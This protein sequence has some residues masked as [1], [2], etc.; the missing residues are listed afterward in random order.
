M[1]TRI[2]LAGPT[3]EPYDQ[4]VPSHPRAVRR[5]SFVA[6]CAALATALTVTP[7][8]PQVRAD[9]GLTIE[10]VNQN[11]AVPDSQVWVTAE[12]TLAGQ[13][14]S[15][16]AA[17]ESLSRRSAFTAA[18]VN[19]GRVSISFDQPVPGP[20]A[21]A[22]SPDTSAIRFDVV[23]LTY[24]GVANLT[25]VDMFGIPLDLEVYDSAGNL[26]GARR[27]ICYTDVIRSQL[28]QRMTAAGGTYSRAERRTGS[29]DFLR[30][31]SPNI[32]SGQNP[33]G[34][35][36]L[37]DYVTSLKGQQLTVRGTFTGSSAQPYDFRGSFSGPGLGTLRLQ[38][39]LGDGLQDVVIDGDTL[40]GNT[41]PDNA[42]YSNNGPYQLGN[43]PADHFVGENDVY[44]AVYRDVVAGFAWG[45]WGS[46]GL[47]N[48]TA[49]FDVSRSPGP[50]EGAQPSHP[51]YNVWAAA[52][53]GYT[54]AYGFPFS[55]TFNDAPGR[56]PLLGL[57]A[58]GTLRII[59][60][61]DQSPS[62]CTSNT[63]DRPDPPSKVTGLKVAVIHFGHK[64]RAKWRAVSMATAYQV[65]WWNKG[66]YTKWKSVTKTQALHK[67]K[68]GRLYKVQVRARTQDVAGPVVTRK[69]RARR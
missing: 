69:F 17:P 63:P 45:F 61:P 21:A 14:P 3:C 66:R 12:Q 50:F 15:V 20:P 24:P 67:V 49:S 7:P 31:V 19:S 60:R 52:L 6:A 16:L 30:L 54:Q 40:P 34:Y 57:P 58:G 36:D 29:G 43:S 44:A 9:S 13:S 55:D 25:A 46:P 38:S 33:T 11:T 56:N 41:P 48:D 28:Q 10:V 42:I 32:S 68:P 5:I 22:P 64:A 53:F 23:E 1:C 62:D 8:V 37:T 18:S 51:Y 65:R 47:G 27:W 26:A 59:V 39:Q 4:G 35:P 2:A